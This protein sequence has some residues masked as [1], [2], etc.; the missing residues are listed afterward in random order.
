M[1]EAIARRS[2]EVLEAQGCV[3]LARCEPKS[4]VRLPRSQ[5]LGTPMSPWLGRIG[6][7]V[8][9]LEKIIK[10]R[11]SR[12]SSTRTARMRLRSPLMREEIIGHRMRARRGVLAVVP[13]AGP[14][15]GGGLR[16]RNAERALMLLHEPA[17]EHGRGIFLQ[18]GI[19]Q[20]ADLFAEIGGMTE[21]RKFVA[22]ERIARSREQKLPGR[23]RLVHGHFIL[24]EA[25]L[26]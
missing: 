23:L 26:G 17:R 10:P 13:A 8:T 5:P 18:P 12:S 24:Q 6:T 20:L 4:T 14:R 7:G 25:K 16:L 19:Q 3:A 1:S 21:P 22:L 9:R 2:G 15:L 11:M